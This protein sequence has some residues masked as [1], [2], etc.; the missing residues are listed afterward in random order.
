MRVYG[1]AAYCAAGA[2]LEVSNALAAEQLLMATHPKP[3]DQKCE[4]AAAVSPCTAAAAFRCA[5][6]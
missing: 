5:A 1:R 4:N 2:L 6:V 3:P